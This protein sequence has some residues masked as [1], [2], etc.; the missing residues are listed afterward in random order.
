M[1]TI[2]SPAHGE[3]VEPRALFLWKASEGRKML[4]RLSLEGKTVILTGGGTGL[5]RRMALHL[6]AAGADLALAGR[7]A[8]PLDAVAAEVQVLGRRA[9]AIPTE[10]TNSAQVDRMVASVI[11]SLGPVDVLVNNAGQSQR[12]LKP[13]WELSNAEWHAGLDSNLTGAFYCS[14]AVARPMV[15]RGRGRIINVSSHWGLRGVR[16]QYVY[17][18]AKG[19]LVQLSRTLAASLSRYGITCVALVPGPFLT[20]ATAHLCEVMP[21][22]EHSPVGYFG[23]S[24]DI[25]PAVVFLASDASEYLN[26]KI[27]PIDGGLLGGGAAPAG[28]APVTPRDP[29]APGGR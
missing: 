4:E 11:Q 6:A 9:L 14:R 17:T 2:P 18:S 5:G 1:P 22:G 28:Y 7:R 20:E 10:I 12:A 15:Q 29:P 13:I 24:E 21:D 3:L 16:D 25:G 19:G 8:A 23:D 27:F 26:G